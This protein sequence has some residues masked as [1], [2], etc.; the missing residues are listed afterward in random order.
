[1]CCATD[2]VM[3]SVLLTAMTFK[4]SQ[5]LIQH[6]IHNVIHNNNTAHATYIYIQDQLINVRN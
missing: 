5:E 3:N 6:V 1:M 4:A 2:L